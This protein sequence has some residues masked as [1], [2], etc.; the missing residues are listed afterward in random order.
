MYL[1]DE[2]DYLAGD[3]M[4]LEK[5]FVLVKKL[6]VTNPSSVL[7]GFQACQFDL[8]M[9][10]IGSV[11]DSKSYFKNWNKAQ[12]LALIKHLNCLCL[13]FNMDYEDFD[14]GEFYWKV[15]DMNAQ[16]KSL[17][18][19]KL[20]EDIRSR[21]RL[22]SGLNGIISTE[23][24]SLINFDARQGLATEISSSKNLL[25]T[26]WKLSILD[27]ILNAT[28]ERND[29]QA[30]I[31]ITV[32][33]IDNLIKGSASLSSTWFFQS[34]Q[35]LSEIPSSH[36]CCQIP[37]SDDP[38]FPL[39][40]KMVGEEVQGNSGS[41][42]EFLAKVIEEVQGSTLPILMPYMGNG[43]F[44]GMFQLQ[45][46]QPSILSEKLLI[47]FGQ[48]IGMAVRCGIPLP[49]SMMPHFWMILVD[50]P[51]TDTYIANYDPDLHRY[52]Q[53]IK[54][55][56][57]P[58][59]FDVFLEQNQY[60]NM[61]WQSI[62]GEEVELTKGGKSSQLSFELR[63]QY[64]DL[65]LELRKNELLCRDKMDCILAGMYTLLPMAFIRGLFTWEE[66]ELKVCGSADIDLNLLKKYSIYQVGI[67]ED[68]RH[69]QDFWSVLQSLSSQQLKKFIKFACNQER[70][71]KP[72]DASFLP[73]PYPLKIAPAD[74]REENQDSLL[75]RAETCIFMVK[76]P[77]YSSYDVMHDKVLYSIQSS[78]DPLSG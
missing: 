22:L 47:Y 20:E 17:L 32:N 66:L 29:D 57:D 6:A 21:L 35:I 59:T 74:A 68:D 75:I 30:C 2:G 63:L 46:G 16:D 61:V 3:K 52:L 38:Q 37:H 48:I 54:T 25:F 5:F 77:R 15:S 36:L 13:K 10:H 53:E 23:I 76:I 44:K 69:I 51:I 24:A 28:A 43:Q 4:D 56:T 60:P 18:E 73:P 9:K 8:D 31:T 78:E 7:R 50:E 42:R 40:I 14:A 62:D 45:P 27:K 39:S 72:Q 34:Y 19:D 26:S 49:L 12:D 67:S 71:P 64:V 55:I 65:I 33:P 41:F 58:D 1:Q 11:S 70:I